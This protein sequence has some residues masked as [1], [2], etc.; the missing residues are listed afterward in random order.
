MD[1]GT[2]GS[3]GA[4]VIRHSPKPDHD[5]RTIPGLCMFI[6]DYGALRGLAQYDPYTL[7]Y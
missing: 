3:K 1:P 5:R 4:T 2:S 6:A 7:L